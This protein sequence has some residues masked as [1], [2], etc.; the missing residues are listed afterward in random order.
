MLSFQQPKESLRSNQPSNPLLVSWLILLAPVVEPQQ[1]NDSCGAEQFVP[2]R[3]VTNNRRGPAHGC[4]QHTCHNMNRYHKNLVL[5]HNQ[6]ISSFFPLKCK[7]AP[8]KLKR[9]PIKISSDCFFNKNWEIC[10]RIIIFASQ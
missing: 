4:H 2:D 1:E 7:R 8:K 9:K 5:V 10:H 3:D 6:I